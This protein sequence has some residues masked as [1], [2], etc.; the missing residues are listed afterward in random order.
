MKIGIMGAMPEEIGPLLEKFTYQSVKYAKNKYY[1][2]QYKEHEIVIAYSKIGKVNT[3]ITASILIEHFGCE[4]ILFSG[5]AGALNL[6]YEIKDIVIANKLVQHDVDITGFGYPFGFIPEGEIFTAC[7]ENLIK[8]ANAVAEENSIKVHN[9]TVATGDQF[10]NDE[11]RKAWIRETFKADAVEMEGASLAVTCQAL[12][13]PCL[14]IRTISDK[15]G[16]EADINFDDFVLESS[17]I[18]A[19]FI[20]KIIDKL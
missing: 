4:M 3:T 7:D 17:Q 10:I 12:K 5:V 1:L 6:D 16:K 14:I 8:I 15:A 13:I 19:D 11:A 9:G 18:S 2:A 20:F